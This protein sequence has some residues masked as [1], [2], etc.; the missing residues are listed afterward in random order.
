MKPLNFFNLPGKSVVITLPFIIMIVIAVSITRCATSPVL[1]K[2]FIENPFPDGSVIY[3]KPGVYDLYGGDNKVMNEKFEKLFKNSLIIEFSKKGYSFT[4]DREKADFELILRKGDAEPFKLDDYYAEQIILR[5]QLMHLKSNK[6][7]VHKWSKLRIS[8]NGRPLDINGEI[9]EFA[10]EAV[11]DIPVNKNPKENKYKIGDRGP[12]GGWIFYDKGIFEDGWRYL[13]AAPLD[14]PQRAEW[15]C[16]GQRIGNLSSFIGEGKNNTKIIIEGC[17][18]EKTAAKLCASYRGGGKKDWFL[19]SKDELEAMYEN[20]H[21]SGIGKFA[22]RKIGWTQY[23]S[24]TESSAEYAEEKC[25]DDATAG[26][27]SKNSKFRVRP[28]RA[29]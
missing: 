17:L 11:K 27:I 12:A 2:R 7:A 6:M 26:A 9:K 5:I 3:V 14:M 20:L 28:V 16:Q 24:S 8:L 10:Q 18:E 15:G 19:P 21:K 22:N 13:E 4:L 29:F 1:E 25:F 23:W